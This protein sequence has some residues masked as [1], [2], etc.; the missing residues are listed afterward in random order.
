MTH[1]HAYIII[2]MCICL[3]N[4]ALHYNTSQFTKLVVCKLTV[5]IMCYTII[6]R[7]IHNRSSWTL[8]INV[9][10][11]MCEVI[12][13]CRKN[14][15]LTHYYYTHVVTLVHCNLN[16][17]YS[18]IS[19][20]IYCISIPYSWFF[21]VL[22]FGEWVIFSFFTIIFSRMHLPKA[23]QCNEWFVFFKGLNFTNEQHPRNSWNL[24]T[25][26]TQLYCNVKYGY[27]I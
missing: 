14:S 6:I 18:H 4:G 22:K 17:I 23:Q 9:F 25:S 12:N 15:P 26:K 2:I 19:L 21:E 16:S 5:Y 24:R 11:R 1:V 13:I 7:L 3:I 27:F 10:I 20:H 8:S